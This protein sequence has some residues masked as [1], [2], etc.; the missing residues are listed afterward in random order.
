MGEGASEVATER[1]LPSGDE[2]GTPPDDRPFRPDIQGLR[3]L[4]V[5]SV[6]LYHAR[7][8]L[9]GGFVGVDV[10][11]V[12]SGFVI[13]GLLLRERGA[14]ART[15][16]PGFYARRARRILPAATLVILVT[17]ACSYAI[18][19]LV[20]GNP[21]A[22]AGRW[23]SVFLS[24][25]HSIWTSSNYFGAQAAQ[26]PLLHF[27][28]LAVEEQ[29]YVV[30]PLLFLIAA[31]L[32]K[33]VPLRIR[34][35]VV[36][37]LVIASSLT[38][39]IL[40]T[41]SNRSIAYLSPFT[42]AWELALGCLVAVVGP[43]WRRI[44]DMSSRILGW[45]GVAGIIASCFVF[46]SSTAYPGAA[47][48]LPTVSTALVIVAGFRV[49]SGGA[50]WLLGR[51]ALL[52]LGALSYSL[53]LWHFPVLLLPEQQAGHALSIG[54]RL[55]LVLVA[56]VLAY[57]TYRLVEN[58]FRHNSS[59]TKSR[60]AS[61]S[62][63]AVLIA[64]T[65]VVCTLYIWGH[66]SSAAPRP[67]TPGVT[68][69]A[70][71]PELEAGATLNALPSVLD[72]PLDQ[73]AG[74]RLTGPDI[75]DRCIIRSTETIEVPKNCTFGDTTSTKTIVLFGDSQAESWA[76]PLNTLAKASG[77]RLKLF[78]K[79][80]CA[81]WRKDYY[82]PPY[83]A[84]GRVFTEC[85]QFQTWATSQ[86]NAL[87]PAAAYLT[88]SEGWTKDPL[89]VE[90]AAS[91]ALTALKP[92]GASLV[93]LS[94]IPWYDTGN[95]GLVPPGCLST[96]ATALSLCNLS[97]GA[98][99]TGDN[100]RFRVELMGAAQATGTRFVVLDP[101]FCTITTCPAVAANR[102]V[103]ENYNHATAA[104]TAHITPAFGQLLKLDGLSSSQK[105]S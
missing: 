28:S 60:R 48:L 4:A 73:L 92:S 9:P 31:S 96:H 41:S 78:V 11:F 86:I 32:F 36:L 74:A 95:N 76:T 8:G 63:G 35:G 44:G 61:L 67:H 52:E 29:F 16:M 19:G 53:Y 69:S 17:V 14:T 105:Q 72:P 59:L 18:L 15:S 55:W 94:N 56:V 51:W 91:A 99:S 45:V 93:L 5:G 37:V 98:A 66:T 24:N 83:V 65:L 39:C 71:I 1:L 101:L 103:Y 26:S 75:P 89:V 82:F 97:A 84:W 70:L 43:H 50:E 88:G 54:N 79:E 57:A 46:S 85:A 22:D 68:I 81:P 25:F 20:A 58:P 38:W 27:W 47:A 77:L 21:T 6:V 80:G 87:H 40:Q 100:G 49:P 10:F 62:M 102:V 13:T 2:A 42:R 12:I 23:T 3:A 7:L 64:L 33:R 34:V 30:F 104:W 90:Q